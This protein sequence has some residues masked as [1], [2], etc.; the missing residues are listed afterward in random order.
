MASTSTN[1]QPLLVDRPLSVVKDTS[2]AV[3]GTFPPGTAI[4]PQTSAGV[5]LVDCT[6]ND[7]A[8]IEYAYTLARAI[9]FES[10]EEDP[11]ED[12]TQVLGTNGYIVNFYFCPSNTVFNPANAYFLGAV[13][14]G[15]DEGQK[16][17]WVDMPFNHAPVANLG[18][19]PE[20]IAEPTYMRGLYV[21]KGQCLWAGAVQQYLD[22]GATDPGTLAPLVGVQGGYY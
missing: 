20:D 5:L 21:P 1:K 13:V 16:V 19:E 12:D 8:V 22:A 14:A 10:Y 18:S 7:G 2:G 15:T 9:D 3:V 4:D 6:K 11:N 17:I